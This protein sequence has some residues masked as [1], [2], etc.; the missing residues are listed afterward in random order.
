MLVCKSLYIHTSAK[1]IN[2]YIYHCLLCDVCLSRSGN[3][4]LPLMLKFLPSSRCLREGCLEK[5]G[6]TQRRSASS[7]KMN[8]NVQ[9]E[10]KATEATEGKETDR[11]SLGADKS[12]LLFIHLGVSP[13]SE[14]SSVLMQET[15]GNRSCIIPAPADLSWEADKRREWKRDRE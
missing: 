6:M 7:P 2:V 9:A 11:R 3:K 13:L 12:F 5:A 1:Q 8:T 14:M 4:Y 10:S 15:L